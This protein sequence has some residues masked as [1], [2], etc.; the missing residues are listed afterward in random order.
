MLKVIA[1]MVTVPMALTAGFIG[2]FC[3]AVTLGVTD[4]TLLTIA[5]GFLAGLTSAHTVNIIWS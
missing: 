3:L 2:G 4:M 1:T 5:G